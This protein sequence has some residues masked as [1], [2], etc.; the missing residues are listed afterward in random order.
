MSNVKLPKYVGPKPTDRV[1]T[2]EEVKA[3]FDAETAEAYSQKDPVYLPEYAFA[4]GLVVEALRAA[5]PPSPRIFDLGAGTGNLSRRVLAGIPGSHVTL[6]DFSDNMLGG[7]KTVL[8][9]FTDRY[10]IVCED[11]FQADFPAGS[12]DGVVSSFAIHHARG[13]EEYLSLYQKIRSWLAPQGVFACCDVIEGGNAGWT[14]VNEEGWKDHLR[15]VS[16][17]EEQIDHIFAN[18]HSEDTPISLPQHLTLLKQ[19]GFASVDVLWKKY[20]FGVYCASSS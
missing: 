12:V 10:D 9:D 19:A 18:Y 7:S 3:R 11:F 2:R 6:V 5:L 20:N 13:E 17:E 4:L 1:L 15:S 14:H 16:F 8:A